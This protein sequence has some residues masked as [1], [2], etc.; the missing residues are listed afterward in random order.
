MLT[1][2]PGWKKFVS[3]VRDKHPESSKLHRLYFVSLLCRA[4]M[5]ICTAHYC[6]K[7]QILLN[8]PLNCKEKLSLRQVGTIVPFVNIPYL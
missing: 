6:F 8:F 7:Y 1:R 3:G 5:P 4:P 2:D